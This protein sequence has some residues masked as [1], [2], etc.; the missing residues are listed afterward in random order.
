MSTKYRARDTLLIETTGVSIEW[1]LHVEFSVSRYRAATLTQPEEPRSVEIENIRAYLCDEVFI[2]LP[3]W[4]EDL[5]TFN[6]EFKARLLEHAA[7]QD[8]V[9]ADDAA[10]AKRERQ[11]EDAR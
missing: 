8:C 3:G 6:A 5:I 4:L 9:A 2:D 11:W 7:E 1:D 10:E